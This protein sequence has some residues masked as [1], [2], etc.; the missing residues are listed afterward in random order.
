MRVLI[1]EDD[2]VSRRILE[3]V[4]TKLGYEVHTT[5]DGNE[6]WECLHGADP[7]QLAILDWMMPG[8]EGIDVCRRLRAEPRDDGRYTYVILLTAKA[9]KSEIIEGIEAGADD[10]IIK[11]FD[12]DELRVRVRA[13]ERVVMLQSQVL[14]AKSRLAVLATHDSLTGAL[15]RRAILEVLDTELSRAGRQGGAVS[16]IMADIDHFKHVNDSCGHQ[17]GDEVL[18]EFVARMQSAVRDYD[19]IGRYGGEEFIILQTGTRDLS[20]EPLPERLCAAVAAEEFSASTGKIRITAS[21]GVATAR[22][23]VKGADLIRAADAALYEAKAAGR[24]C[25]R[26]ASRVPEP[27]V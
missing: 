9:E 19:C 5:H 21:F 20:P 14:E 3:S 7:P 8:M 10:Y 2:A 22:S 16:V 4:L 11:P 25:V 24:N 13:G 6:A 18:Q 23:Y 27:Q 1:A 17:T 15:N 12:K 26:F